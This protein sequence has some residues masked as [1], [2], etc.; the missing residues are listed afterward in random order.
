MKNKQKTSDAR[1]EYQYEFNKRRRER[2]V[3]EH[4]CISCGKG[5]I[6]PVMVYHTRCPK[7]LKK[8]KESKIRCLEKNKRK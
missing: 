5:D 1:R 8:L 6:Q 4:K 3:E 2:L 7:C